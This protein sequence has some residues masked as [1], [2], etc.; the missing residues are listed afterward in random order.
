MTGPVASEPGTDAHASMGTTGIRDSARAIGM[1]L[2]AGL[3]FRIIIAYLLP[4]SGFKVDLGAFEY[5][6]RNLADQGAAGFYDRG[7]F[8]DYTPGYL[9]VL[10]AVGLVG[11]LFNRVG[12]QAVGPWTFTDLLKLPSILADV[13]IGYLIYR[14]VLDL[15]ASKRRAV[16]GAAIFLFNPISWF[17][18]TVWGQVDAFGVVFLLLGVRELWRDHPE[19]SA[20]F[21]TVAAVIKPQL[22]ILV[23]IVAAVVIRR[24]LFDSPADEPSRW[25]RATADGGILGTFRAWG[26]RERGPIRVVTTAT[27]GLATAVLLS[28]PFGLTIFDLFRQIASTAGGYP[29]LTVNAYNPWAL[30]T[31]DGNG[32]AANSLWIRDVNG[33][34]PGDVG[35]AFGPVP[36]VIVGTVLLLGAVA[37][38]SWLVAR[39]PD[40]LTILIG[41]SVLALAFFVLPTRVHERYLYPLFALG[42]I[43]AAVS[44]RWRIA[45]VALS[46]VSFLNMYVVLTTLYPDNPGISD[47][48]GIG[49][50]IRS[51]TTITIIALVHLGGFVWLSGQLRRSA[52]RR[53]VAEILAGR[54]ADPGP[55]GEP[56]DGLPEVLDEGDG[57]A[58]D[59]DALRTQ[60]AL[61]AATHGTPAEL[62][63]WGVATAPDA[64]ADGPSWRP[65]PVLERR[66]GSWS[67]APDGRHSGWR[68]S[69]RR[70]VLARP[71]RANRSRA[72]HGEK[73]GRIDRLDVWFF[74]VVVIAALTLRTFR[75]AEPYSMHFDEVYHARTATE[76]LQFWRYGMP[77]DIYEYTHPHLAKYAMAGG[78][79][80]VG[81]NQV[82]SRSSLDVPV[83][84][85]AIELRWND[86]TT[87]GG[88]A[89]D[90]VYVATGSEVRV[91]DLASRAL[92][93]TIAAPGASTLA[94]DQTAHRLYIGN[95]AGE[96]VS[97]DTSAGLDPLRAHPGNPA[98]GPPTEPFAT[99]GGPLRQLMVP[100]DASEVVAATMADDVASLDGATGAELART[101]V[102]GLRQ[103]L[104]AGTTQQVV[105]QPALL[106][107]PPAA[108]A[109]LAELL[110]KTE[111]EIE[112]DLRATTGT[113]LLGP[114]PTASARTT[115][116][117]ATA[118]GRLPGVTVQSLPQLAAV[119]GTGLTFFAPAS[120][121]VIQ[122]LAIAGATGAAYVTGLDAPRIYVAAGSKVP[123]VRLPGDANANQAAYTEST[124]LA[125]GQVQQ[126]TFDPATNFVHVLGRTQDGSAP[127]IYVIEPHGNAIFA[128][129]KLPFEPAAWVTD[130]QP[131]Y[132]SQDRQDLLAFSAD[133]GVATIDIGNNPFA[134]R[135]PG[136]ILGA[137]TAGLLYLLARILF[138]RRTVAIFVG[139]FCLAD[140]MAFVQSRIGMN[141]V[142]VGFFIVAAY[143]LFAALWT[144][145]IRHRWAFW[146]AMPTIGVLLGLALSSKWVGL[147]AMAGIGILVLAR[148][149]LG[150]LI[151]VLGMIGATTALG[152][153]AL[154]VPTG[155][156]SGGNLIFMLIMIGL[157]MA[158]VLISV[159]HPISWSVEEVRFAVAG[160]AAL[161]IAAILVALPLDKLSSGVVVGSVKIT[162]LTGGLGLVLASAGVAAAFWAAG[163]L[164]F[165][166]M[167]PSLPDD[168]AARL[169]PAA[170]APEGWLRLGSGFGIPVAWMTASL[171]LLPILVYVISYL[172]WVAL[173]NRLT[174][175]W[176]PGNHGQTLLDLTKS[177]YDYHNNLRAPHAA[178]SPWWAWPFDLKP[179]WFYQG[180]FDGS[181]AAS[182]YDAGNLAIWWLG[183]PAMIFCAWQAYR[184]QSLGLALIVLGYA[185]QWLPWARIDRATFQYHYYTSVPFLILALAYFMAELWHGASKR[186]W[187]M[188]KVAAA[189][190][191]MGPALLW[192]GKGPLCRY[193][194]VEA[195]N[196][197]SQACVGNPGDI[198][199][200]ARIALLVLVL[201]IA[202]IALVYQLLRLS[203]PG[204]GRGGGSGGGVAEDEDIPPVGGRLPRGLT[205][206]GLTA[207]A[208]GIAI[209]IA[210]RLAGDGVVFEVRGFQ[211]TYL[212][213]VLGVPLV[214]IGLFVLTA[215][216]ARRFVAGTLFAIVAAFLLIYPNISALPLPSAVVNA[217]QGLLPTYLYP[218]QFP[219][220]TDPA[221]PG[222]RLFSLEPALL[223]IALTVTCVVVGY[224]AWV[225]RIGPVD[226][227]APGD[228]SLPADGEA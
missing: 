190:A 197:G 225:W 63:P 207:I 142:Y 96:I 48:L 55:A 95:D 8:A 137:L 126:V 102:A 98:T 47:W 88:Y 104:E 220:N 162:V 204:G 157:T 138:R 85:A 191:V 151:L 214:L 11:D 203:S 52:E 100:H 186:T 73:G 167:A 146:L 189:L 110:G 173:G 107:D 180:S 144:K 1:V 183:I 120:G 174:D 198:V 61:A 129:A 76:F 35:F 209:A 147:Y 159:L 41:V 87:A 94:L 10:W 187:L 62:I 9:Y 149:A 200:T 223:L 148:S 210:D 27:A 89:G 29:Y 37:V 177:M 13:A 115:L 78:L 117:Q 193:V 125:P 90:R 222:L 65:D 195:V 75:L 181:T 93:A 112:T 34:N 17:D 212:A 139:I 116:D 31:Q 22:G 46:I 163:R 224:A 45:Y 81:D 101:H 44:G 194:R 40:R 140:G 72:L 83:E 103:I 60:P 82:T 23:P 25:Q 50:D 169:T 54:A 145:Q 227:L 33:P 217:Y 39:R 166:P 58:A 86:A 185:W 19:R 79:I 7:F 43:L 74:V 171:I 134:W 228:G 49:P 176:P 124:I 66:A 80:A 15:G 42:A 153:M 36:A 156:T 30:L 127:T 128:D 64:V 131:L 219:V 143:T 32:L 4:G 77:H 119:T 26:A 132:P 20:I 218:F 111:A 152:Y 160:P 211:S 170:P 3:V 92:V 182:I 215:R 21:A 118:D 69:L 109:L 5:W 184:R 108:A 179:V 114:P 172:P 216:D 178:S 67:D 206:I 208:A 12:I 168:V 68:A 201:G 150:R 226:R 16:I 71:L 175:T 213:F 84:D 2:A 135:L 161:G 57:L 199:V 130:A 154:S 24:Y 158:A 18:S 6:A 70:A 38:V 165:G 51:M 205:Q 14:L 123:V 122:Q 121:L 133:G 136:V 202:V 59:L 113:V 28:L 106:S 221:A 56:D 91:Y 196:P 141:D 164:G 105:A 155:A 99:V 97:V 192:I 53:L 188:A